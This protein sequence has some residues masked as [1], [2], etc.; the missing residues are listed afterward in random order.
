[1]SQKGLNLKSLEI[2]VCYYP[3]HW[4]KSFWKDDLARMK[5]NGI[6]TIRIAEFAWSIFEPREGEYTFEFFDEFLKLVE[7]T[8]IKVIFGT[9]TATPPAWLTKKYKEVLNVDKEGNFFNHGCRRHYNYNSKKYNELSSKIVEQLAI[10]YGEHPNII[11]WQIDNE[12]NCENDEFY[13]ESDK[14]EFVNFLK[15]KYNEIENLNKA[16]GAIFWN[17]TYSDWS[18][19]D[20]PR[21][22]NFDTNNLHQLLDYYRFISY[23]V[24]RYAKMQNTIL[25]KHIN[26]RMFITTN[27]MFDN[28]D[29]HRLTKESLDFYTYDSYPNFGYDMYTDPNNLDSLKDRWW[30]RNLSEVRSISNNFGIMEQQSGANGWNNRMEAP[31][32]KPGQ[33]M[34]WTMQSVAHGA[35]FISYFRWRTCTQGTEIYWH[36][37]LDYSNRDNRRLNEVNK[38]SKLFSNLNE[39]AGSKYKAK[40]AI[41]KDYDNVWDKKIDNWHSRVENISQE[42][43]FIATQLSHTPMDY[44]YLQDDTEIKNLN[45]YEFLFYPHASIMTA[46]RA[47]LLK[48]YVENGGKIIFG[49]RT[50][51]KDITGKCPVEKLPWLLRDLTGTDVVEYTLVGPYD[52]EIK[53]KLDDRTINAPGFNDVLETLGEN[54][55]VLGRFENNFYKGSVGLIENSY[56]KGRAYYFGGAFDKESTLDLLEKFNLSTPYKNI[57]EL[58]KECELAVREKENIQYIF[59]LNYSA[60]DKNIIL[61]EKL[62]NLYNNKEIIGDIVLKAFET[63]VLKKVNI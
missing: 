58:P 38:V 55:K 21:K 31:T 6:S 20:L 34:L 46:D 50:A 23:S 39:I 32:P 41:V 25:R 42:G 33:L 36:G 40:I 26:E 37:I 54:S 18:E 14:I 2:G 61:K 28:I 8:D 51:Y 49:S 30:S 9:P 17:Q 1:M 10:H 19:V 44:L 60:E 35:D 13:S 29:N 27:G 12:F 52:G 63:I 4:D 7:A 5:A 22:V 24:C 47:N 48:K 57:L 3:E 16:W 45:Q 15:D 59:V 43:I 11:G 56:G 62:L 53:V